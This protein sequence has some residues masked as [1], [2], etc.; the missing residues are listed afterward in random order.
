MNMGVWAERNGVARVRVY[1]WFQA[2]LLSVAAQGVG[3]LILVN[4][5]AEA[6]PG[7]M[8]V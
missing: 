7:R 4:D 6:P 2:G 1:R 5:A 3:R 8:A